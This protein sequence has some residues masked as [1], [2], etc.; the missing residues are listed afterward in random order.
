MPR[1]H[2]ELP[3][4]LGKFKTESIISQGDA[5]TFRTEAGKLGDRYL[6]ITYLE[7]P[8]AFKASI[9]AEFLENEIIDRYCEQNA[10]I[11]ELRLADETV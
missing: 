4:W 5:A 2:K 3:E 11:P 1:W 8:T 6:A 7:I 9:Y 10:M